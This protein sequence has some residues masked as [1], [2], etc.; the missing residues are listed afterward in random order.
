MK[1]S[2]KTLKLSERTHNFSLTKRFVP[3]IFNESAITDCTGYYIWTDRTNIYFS[4]DYNHYIF[5]KEISAWEPKVWEWESTIAN[6]SFSGRNVWTN[7]TDIY[8]SATSKQWVLDGNTWKVKTWNWKI[9]DS[10][11]T[12]P[13]IL[14]AECVWTDGEDIYL[15]MGNYSVPYDKQWVLNKELNQWEIKTWNGVEDPNPEYIWTDGTNIYYSDTTKNYILNKETSTW[16]T[17]TWNGLSTTL[18]ANA[19]WTD[20]TNIYFSMSNSHYILDVETSTWL[21]TSWE[22]STSLIGSFYVSSSVRG[23]SRDYFWTDGVNLYNSSSGKNAILLPTTAKIYQ[24]VGNGS[25]NEWMEIKEIQDSSMPIEVSNELEMR[26]LLKI[27]DVG[28]IYKYTGATTDTYEK[29]ALYVVDW[30]LISF[31]IDG[32]AYQAV[33]G[34]TWAEW[35]SSK[36]NVGN[37]SVNTNG[38][39]C[40]YKNYSVYSDESTLCTKDEEIIAN[41]AY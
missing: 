16:E 26:A 38:I 19:I 32:V 4:N 2:C 28:S 36:Y 27:A 41:V 15:S 29:D 6:Q 21:P 8:I 31:T 34:M 37:Y 22:G 5:N 1:T 20:G 9:D 14:R 24:R 25:S 40:L 10:V 39:V 30:N 12:T 17:K 13:E 18:R 3:K 7:G 23:W 35:V 33:E 11:T